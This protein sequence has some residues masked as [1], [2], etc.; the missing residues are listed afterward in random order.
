MKVAALLF[1]LLSFMNFAEAQSSIADAIFLNGNIYTGTKLLRWDWSP[2][3]AQRNPASRRVQAIAIRE[4]RILAVGIRCPAQAV[5]GSAIP[6]GASG[7]FPGQRDF[8]GRE[9]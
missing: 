3:S 4:G 1:C 5:A 6:V 7:A 9:T 8:G 2:S